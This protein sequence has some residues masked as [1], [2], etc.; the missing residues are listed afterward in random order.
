M[1]ALLVD[2]A[3]EW[4]GGQSQ[5]LLT[6]RGLRARGH[7]VSLA[8]R[9]GGVL[10]GR[11]RD[12]GFAL[13]PLRFGG[14]LAPGAVASLV[15]A[16][17]R[18]RPDVVQLND[19]HSCAA[20]LLAARLA[21]VRRR[22]AMRRVD[23]HLR[24][25]LS[26]LK[27]GAADRVIAVSRAILEILRDDGL[28]P[29][30]LRLVYEGVPDRAPAAGGAAALRALGVPEGCPVVGNVAALTDHKDHAT[31]L[32]AAAL[33]LE[34]LPEARFVIVGD[35]ERRAALAQQAQR[36]GLDG[37]CLFAGFRDDVDRLLPAFTVFCLS[38]HKE[39]LGTSLLDAMAF[40]RPV[41]ATAAGGIP[42]AVADGVTGRVVPVRDPAA[43]AAALT[44]LLRD[45]LLRETLG[46]QGRRRF[47]QHFTAERMVEETLRVFEE[48]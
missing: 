45:A 4:R 34:R 41:V 21:G 33:V 27:Y 20:G 14:D 8:C 13:Q 28:D 5:L 9:A 29:R 37:R 35:G 38:S 7:E 2:A 10:A 48:P 46:R 40:G 44:E 3:H 32:S 42:E 26:R 36:L 25:R 23:F 15:A 12:E 18:F 22:V 39:G 11:A 16:I 43:L 24:G 6:A 30:K 19:P 31:L 17:R 1:R 47:E